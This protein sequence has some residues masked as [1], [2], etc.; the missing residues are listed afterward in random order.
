MANGTKD[1]GL[2]A[3]PAAE[4]KIE[5]AEQGAA[6]RPQRPKKKRNV[7]KIVLVSALVLAVGA[8]AV[9]R[10][11]AMLR[12]PLPTYAPTQPVAVGDVTQT[13]S[14]TGTLV[15]GNRVTVLSPV[16]APLSEVL[17]EQGQVVR[18]GDPLFRF[19]TTALQ[20]AY[21]QASAA[22]ESGQLQKSDALAASSDAQAQF[23]DAAASLNNL[24]V[25]KDNAAAAV[26]SLA[27]QYAA[28]TEEQKN[29]E[30]GKTLS[31]ALEAARADLA[32]QE[33]ALSAAKAA[34]DAAQKG[35]LSD[36]GKRELE[37]AQVPTAVSVE[38]AREDLNAAKA[39][40]TAPIGGVVTGLSAVQ[41]GMAGSYTALCTVESL[42]DVDVDIALSRYDLEK[43]K[44]GQSAAVTTLGRTY[45]GTVSAIDAMATAG[46][47][48]GGT[49]TAY[50]HAKIH[51]DAP[52]ENLKLGIEANV[53]ILTGE[54]K[55][56]LSLPLGAVNTDVG[57]QF[58]LVVE[59]GVAVRREVVT[60]LS[61]DTVVEIT[62]G[63][64]A[65]DVV[66]TDP[67]GISEGMAVSGDPGAA[68]PAA[69]GIAGGAVMIG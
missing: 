58:C 16:S 41:G 1:E 57:G 67:L 22:Y 50:V 18:A 21:R 19:D 13:L 69:G 38:A 44:V 7:K 52:D 37:L 33:Q 61:S 62:S 63:L 43:V 54:A 10:V 45:T 8:F 3:A 36:S 9:S 2:A 60:G 49:A 31:A 56:V 17:V 55:N 4:E 30:Q 48:T 6:A 28:L 11:A 64:S 25:Q 26:S 15:S 20:R 32:G 5:L 23:N 59:N 40:L 24:A 27:S 53:V 46:A 65:G 34:Y 14:T 12:G 66:I 47:G 42:E 39:G 68:V 29:G 35:V 51:L